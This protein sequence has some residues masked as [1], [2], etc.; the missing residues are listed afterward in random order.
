MLE[1]LQQLMRDVVVLGPRVRQPLDAV[2]VRVLR[3]GEAAV[4]QAQ[5]AQQV[6][7]GLLDDL[8]IAR[9]PG[10]DP[11][12]QVRR[13]EQRVVVQHLLEV[14]DQPLAVDGVAV[15]AA[16]DEVVH[17]AERHRVERLRHQ[18][19]LVA[20]QQELERRRGR[21]LRRVAEA[22]PHGIERAAQP[23][24]RRRR[25][26][27]APAARATAR[28]SRRRLLGDRAARRARSRRA[29]RAT[30]RRPRP[31]AA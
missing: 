17:P 20:P 31:A 12:V 24:R 1:R 19:E 29:A 6:V 11:G 5:L 10:H 30:P 25:A 14:R 13:D 27:T 2:R 8:A 4:G 16:A 26:A 7:R 3:G 18:L 15:E 23:S 28:A 22:A 21:E 9:V